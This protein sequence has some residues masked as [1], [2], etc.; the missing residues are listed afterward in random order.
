[1]AH[2]K[3]QQTLA[4]H[5]SHKILTAMDI[6]IVSGNSKDLFA[7]DRKP[8]QVSIS[9]CGHNYALLALL[10]PCTLCITLGFNFKFAQ[11]LSFLHKALYGYSLVVFFWEKIM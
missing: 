10:V 6:C 7:D 9:K 1:M 4:C 5:Q 2:Q 11:H 3:G 8:S